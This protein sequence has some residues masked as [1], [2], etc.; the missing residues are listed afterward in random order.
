MHAKFSY[1]KDQ[2]E[3]PRERERH[4]KS[5]S[6]DHMRREVAW[7]FYFFLLRASI[8]PFSISS[9][10]V[11]GCWTA[12]G[13]WTEKQFTPISFSRPPAPIWLF[14]ARNTIVSRPFLSHL[15]GS[16]AVLGWLAFN[17]KVASRATRIGPARG[18]V[19]MDS[20]QQNTRSRADCCKQS[21]SNHGN[22]PFAA[23]P[24]VT[25]KAGCVLCSAHVHAS[26]DWLCR[27][28]VLNHNQEVLNP[29]FPCM[30]VSRVT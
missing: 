1:P 15:P 6:I 3:R 22:R 2:P 13:T 29:H 7:L 24:Q 25:A 19:L 27:F 14:V 11:G 30:S 4:T 9:N 26:T 8:L 28:A 5:K 18:R 10:L 20:L 21:L 12:R 23:L 17:V 16:T